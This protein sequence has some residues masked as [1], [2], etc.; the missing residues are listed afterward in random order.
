[1]LTFVG[2]WTNQI[3]GDL[4]LADYALLTL[5]LSDPWQSS[6]GVYKETLRNKLSLTCGSVHGLYLM[7]Q[8]G[9]YGSDLSSSLCSFYV[10]I[11]S[12]G[13]E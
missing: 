2:N 12:D 8:N 5:L 7:F 4:Y 11:S 1:L 3:K 6:D 10:S 13:H 9:T